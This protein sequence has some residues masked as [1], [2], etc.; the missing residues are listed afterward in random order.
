LNDALAQIDG[1]WKVRHEGRWLAI[2][3]RDPQAEA[4]RIVGALLEGEPSDPLVVIG[5]GLGYVLDA[6]EPEPSTVEAMQA[7][8]DWSAWRAGDRLR[9]LTAPAFTGAADC[10]PWFGDGGAAP[11]TYVHPVLQRIRPAA[12]AAARAVAD[13]IRF[14]AANNAEARRQ[15]GARYVL[16]TLRNLRAI[17]EEPGAA[18]LFGA[19]PQRPAIIAAAGP[20]LD[21]ALASL[22]QAQHSALIIAVDTALRPLLQAGIA[23]HLVVAVDPSEANGRHLLDLPECAATHL[24]AEASIDP[25]AL[26]A[27]RGRSFVFA[28]SDHEPWPW[29]SSIGRRPARLRA[30]GSVLTTAFDLAVNMGCNPIAFVG[31]DLAYSGARPYCRG[32][33]FEEDWQRLAHWGEPPARQF[34]DAIARFDA[35]VQP[36]VTGGEVRTAPHLIAFRDWLVEQIGKEQERRFVNATGAGI[37]LGPRIEQTTPQELLAQLG[38]HTRGAADDVIASRYRRGDGSHTLEAASRLTEAL[39]RH[40]VEAEAVLA[41]WAAFAPGLSREAAIE[42][43]RTGCGAPVGASRRDPRGAEQTEVATTPAAHAEIGFEPVWLQQLADAMP[44]VPFVLPPHRLQVA[45]SGARVFRFRTTTARIICCTLR[46]MEGAVAE[47]GQAM[48]RALDLDHVVPGS[49]S[50]CRD[51]VHFR[52]ADDSDPRLNGREYTLLVPPPIA[53]VEGLPLETILRHRL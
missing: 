8:R 27:F 5:L 35:A 22:Q 53:Y 37:L 30:W 18:E 44:L 33:T 15:Q 38:P 48:V 43:L 9:V 1:M 19:A 2:H 6:L 50:V 20:S 46:P 13:R 45:P 28:V 7:R 41:R 17:A 32:V 39:V 11:L 34:R 23:P 29:L 25:L 42:A 26:R 4:D 10:W 47:D 51:E 21:A 40:A 3:G 24:V 52:P 12:V 31:A 36:D 49:Y 14:D 16:N